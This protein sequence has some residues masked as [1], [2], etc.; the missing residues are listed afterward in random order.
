MPAASGRGAISPPSSPPPPPPPP[1]PSSSFWTFSL[2]AFSAFSSSSRS[3]SALRTFLNPSGSSGSASFT[4]G[5][6]CASAHARDRRISASVMNPS[7]IAIVC[8][9]TLRSVLSSGAFYTSDDIG[10]E[11]KGVSW[12]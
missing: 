3:M 4:L 12:S 2:A 10:V 7:H 1:P 11:L 9:C 5:S 8:Q 6:A